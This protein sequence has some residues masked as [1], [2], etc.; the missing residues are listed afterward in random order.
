[1]ASALARIQEQRAQRLLDALQSDLRAQMRA[2]ASD[3]VVSGAESTR[4]RMKR[5]LKRLADPQTRERVWSAARAPEL[6][7]REV[8]SLPKSRAFWTQVGDLAHWSKSALDAACELLDLDGGATGKKQ[9]LVARI[10]DWIHEPELRAMREEQARRDKE[11]DAVLGMR[12]CVCVCVL[13][14]MKV[15]QY[16]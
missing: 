10:Q 8:R 12:V 2:D 6:D 4:A 15:V 14:C 7:G 1:M 16:H 13:F 11:R 9:E 5:R 3:G